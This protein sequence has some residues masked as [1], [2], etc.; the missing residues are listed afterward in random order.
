MK[1]QKCVRCGGASCLL[2][3][4]H[5][6]HDHRRLNVDGHRQRYAEAIGSLDLPRAVLRL[7]F[8]SLRVR[9]HMHHVGVK[10]AKLGHLLIG[11]IG[12]DDEAQ[13]RQPPNR[14]QRFTRVHR[15]ILGRCDEKSNVI[16][17]HNRSEGAR[18]LRY[19]PQL[20]LRLLAFRRVRDPRAPSL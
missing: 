19:T 10:D 7:P 11:V 18:G 4:E 16:D 2:S 15:M 12:D 13:A 3:V 20:A 14:R 5:R 9:Q 17:R 1:L 8:A 6:H